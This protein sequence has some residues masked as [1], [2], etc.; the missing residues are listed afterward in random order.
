MPT[1]SMPSSESR[2]PGALAVAVA[3][4]AVALALIV[5]RVV[6]FDAYWLFRESPPW[7]A[8]TGGA[9]RLLD[10]QTRRS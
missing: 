7:L 2:W 10:R 8:E 4:L 1:S 9:N 5:G 3:T 6:W